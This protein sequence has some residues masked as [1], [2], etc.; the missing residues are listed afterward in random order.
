MF[1]DLQKLDQSQ[2]GPEYI[3]LLQR[4]CHCYYILDIM[5]DVS[6]HDYIIM[7]TGPS[8]KSNRILYMDTNM[9]VL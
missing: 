7:G 6:I 4:Q 3:Q 8:V 1:K 9:D 5:I 2:S